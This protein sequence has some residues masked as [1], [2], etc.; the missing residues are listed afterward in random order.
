M[1]PK[2]EENGITLECTCE[3]IIHKD[4]FGSAL[5]IKRII[6]NLITNALKYNNKTAR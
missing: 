4:L 1:N 5:A 6:I 2:A 3:N